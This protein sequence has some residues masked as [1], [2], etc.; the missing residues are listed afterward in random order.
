MSDN[1]TEG[2]GYAHRRYAESLREFGEP[3]ELQ[4]SGGWILERPIPG[5][6]F[7]DAMGCYPLFACRDWSKLSEDMKQV[8]SDLVSLVFVAEPFADIPSGLEEHFDFVRP[9]KTHY[10]ADLSYSLESLVNP[11]HRSQARKSLTIMDVEICHEPAKYLD[12]WVLLYDN[13]IRRHNISGISAFSYRSFEIQLNTPG[14]IMALGRCEGEIVGAM[15]ALVRGQVAYTHL[16]ACSKRGY[17]T[18]ASCGILWKL[19]TC[20]QQQGVRY[21][22]NGGVAGIKDDQRNGLAHFKRGWSNDRRTVY[23]YGRVLNREKYESLCRRNK[24]ASTDYFP[25]YRGS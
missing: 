4:H 21:L 6:P 1:L 20:L 16:S 22:D 19:L 18:N 8:A 2:M 9:F 25:A 3:R 12:D 11:R 7:K 24:I 15:L 23:L 10:V 5:A 13:L 14:M 17:K